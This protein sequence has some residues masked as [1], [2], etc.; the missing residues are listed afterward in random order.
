MARISEFA[1][2]GNFCQVQI[3]TDIFSIDGNMFGIEGSAFI[4]LME[5]CRS[6]HRWKHDLMES[7]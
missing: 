1:I 5:M 2:D 7:Q 6:F 3:V 4:V